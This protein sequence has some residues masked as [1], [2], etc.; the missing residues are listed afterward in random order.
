MQRV[1][2][3]RPSKAALGWCCMLS[4]VA[5]IT[6]GFVWGGWVT[7]GTAAEMANKAADGASA[8][9]AAAIC[10]VQFANDPAATVQRAAL[11]KL[12]TWQRADFITKGGWAI[13]PGMKDPVAGAADLCAEQVALPTEK[14]AGT[15][16]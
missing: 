4:V 2:A 1:E 16:G 11:N 5:T 12:N 10:A 15:S 6:I 14:T 3:Y 9:L 8:K 7:G 13:L